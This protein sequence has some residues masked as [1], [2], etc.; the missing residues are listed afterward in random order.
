[1]ALKNK[2]PATPDTP[3]AEVRLVRIHAT[4]PILVTQADAIE[5]PIPGIQIR[6]PRYLCLRGNASNRLDLGASLV[7]PETMTAEVVALQPDAHAKGYT[8]SSGVLRSGDE[9]CV[10]LRNHTLRTVE[11]PE[12]SII[13]TLT[14]RR[15]RATTIAIEVDPVLVAR[16]KVTR[17]GRVVDEE[18]DTSN[19]I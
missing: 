11:F 13:G 6:T 18:L 5:E 14:F 2:K 1:M 17:D 12:G 8:V 3:E 19:D 15:H 4:N 7:M 9:V 16:E 10:F